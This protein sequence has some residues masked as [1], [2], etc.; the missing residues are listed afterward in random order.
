MNDYDWFF[1]LYE[2]MLEICVCVG[3]N[4]VGGVEMLS[5]NYLYYKIVSKMI[6]FV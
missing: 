5:C 4:G 2:F 1:V 6:M 3:E